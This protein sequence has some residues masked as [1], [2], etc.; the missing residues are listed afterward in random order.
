MLFIV[1]DTKVGNTR[2]VAE[3]LRETFLNEGELESVVIPVSEFYLT[4][5]VHSEKTHRVIMVTPT[6][7]NLRE[8]RLSPEAPMKYT[9]KTVRDET[10]AAAAE[11]TLVGVVVCGNTN[12]GSK[13]CA[14]KND[15]HP[16]IKILREIDV[17]GNQ[18]DY[19]AVV[20]Q[21]PPF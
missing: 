8:Q 1:Y 6:Y 18:D 11:G 4:R 13:F 10:N 16:A 7:E 20:E 14:A 19:A 21:T 12:F 17:Q 5:Y 15:F 2:K 9:T 3:R